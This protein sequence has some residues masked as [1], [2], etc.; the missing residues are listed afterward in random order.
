MPHIH[1]TSTCMYASYT[2]MR[3]YLHVHTRLCVCVYCACLLRV[4]GER[5]VKNLLAKCQANRSQQ[6]ANSNWQA[7][8]KSQHEP[9]HTH[10][11]AHSNVLIPPH[12]TT[13]IYR[14]AAYK[15]LAVLHIVPRQFSGC[16][17]AFV[18]F[19]CG[20]CVRFAGHDGNKS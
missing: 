10:T 19:L 9:T 3:V 4:Y 17:K 8:N 15:A 11:H 14:H 2:C 16:H 13:H 20:F 5:K 1:T 6:K 18:S 12:T 7:I